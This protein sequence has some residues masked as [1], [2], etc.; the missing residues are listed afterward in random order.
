M[1]PYNIKEE[2]DQGEGHFWAVFAVYKVGGR[3]MTHMQGVLNF[4]NF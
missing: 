4:T 3:K 1:F 2:E